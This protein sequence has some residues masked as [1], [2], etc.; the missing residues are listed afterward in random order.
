MQHLAKRPT[1]ISTWC[2]TG[3]QP[4]SKAQHQTRH[5]L[6]CWKKRGLRRGAVFV[7]E[8]SY[9]KPP[10]TKKTVNRSLQR[11]P[12]TGVFSWK[13]V[14][15]RHSN[16]HHCTLQVQLHSNSGYIIHICVAG[17]LDSH[18]SIIILIYSIDMHTHT[19]T[20]IHHLFGQNRVSIMK[21][22][23][24]PPP[25]SK[26]YHEWNMHRYT[27]PDQERYRRS[28]DQRWTLKRMHTWGHLTKT[29]QF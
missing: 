4:V 16:F 5:C 23:L 12:E 6:K 9:K 25:S 7:E 28:S 21:Q 22:P 13:V 1:Q 24:P 26:W 27:V 10:V 8:S 19:H 17:Q 20:H 11:G 2:L 18:T 29:F 3:N 14:I 15:T